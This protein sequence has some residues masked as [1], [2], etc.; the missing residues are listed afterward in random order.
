MYVGSEDIAPPF[1]TSAL[2]RG[3]LHG[4]AALSPG[5]EPLLVGPRAGLGAM[6][7]RIIL[8]LLGIEPRPSS[9]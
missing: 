6:G 9:P 1:L 5:K 4:P 8:P 3:P 7:K 2:D